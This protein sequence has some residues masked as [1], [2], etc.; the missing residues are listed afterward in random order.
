[1]LAVALAACGA[2]HGAIAQGAMPARVAEARW[3]ARLSVPLRVP[4]SA[5][6]AAPASGSDSSRGAVKRGVSEVEIAL[7][8]AGSAVGMYGGAVA[9]LY[10]SGAAYGC[11]ASCSIGGPNGCV[12]SCGDDAFLGVVVGLTTGSILGTALGTR[13]GAKLAHRPLGGLGQRLLAGGVGFLAAIGAVALT[14]PHGENTVALIAFP[15]VQGVVGAL[16]GGQW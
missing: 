1:V 3:D 7:G 5:R 4:G 10:A 2:A 6:D 13:L 16:M 8:I 15:V 11:P 9:G 14:G 12:D